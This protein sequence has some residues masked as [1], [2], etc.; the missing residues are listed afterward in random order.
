MLIY[1]IPLDYLKIAKQLNVVA[2]IFS[3]NFVTEELISQAHQNGFKVFVYTVNEPRDI[4]KMKAVQVD[5]IFTNYPER[6]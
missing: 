1:G 2:I 5:G 3:I 6:V 4:H